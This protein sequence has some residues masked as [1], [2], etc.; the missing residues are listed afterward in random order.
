MKV[1]KKDYPF[2]ITIEDKIG[3]TSG[4]MYQ[5]IG[6]SY[7]RVKNKD[8]TD[9]KEK[10]ETV[11]INFFDESELLKLSSLAENAYLEL[12]N[13]REEEK[14]QKKEE[15]K[16]TKGMTPPTIESSPLLDDD[17]PFN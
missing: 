11:Y 10:Y 16:L 9:P 8:A 4:K 2:S 15:D 1:V 12:N 14:K 6:V 5:A 17:I 3:K 13:A 7:T